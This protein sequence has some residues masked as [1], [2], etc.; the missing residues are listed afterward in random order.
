TGAQL[1][2]RNGQG[3]YAGLAIPYRQ[4]WD[5]NNVVLWV[6]RR[7]HPEYEASNGKPKEKGKYLVAPGSRQRFYF[8]PSVSEEMLSDVSLPILL[9]EGEKK[10]L[11]AW[12]LAWHGLGE[13]AEKPHF[14]PIGLRGVYGFR[15]KTGKETAP[16]GSTVDVRGAI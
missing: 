15:G 8:P 9:V 13:S 16:D 14:L 1:A 4:P 6:L 3:D 7:D 12:A 11:A 5:P 10:A 2:G